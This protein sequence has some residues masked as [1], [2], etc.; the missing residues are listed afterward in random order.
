MKGSVRGEFKW[1][2]LGVLQLSDL[3]EP[4]KGTA[5]SARCYER[6]REHVRIVKT[7]IK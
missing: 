2:S 6:T 3:E 1:C 4:G 5:K 7:K